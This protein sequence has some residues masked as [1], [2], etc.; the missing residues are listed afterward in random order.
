MVRI[1][2][3]DRGGWVLWGHSWCR[4]QGLQCRPGT[5]EGLGASAQLLQEGVDLRQKGQ[6][7]QFGVSSMA[8]LNVIPLAKLQRLPGG[9]ALSFLGPSPLPPSGPCQLQIA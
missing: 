4:L 7:T 1:S 9:C 6:G 5:W 8:A 2:L 3:E